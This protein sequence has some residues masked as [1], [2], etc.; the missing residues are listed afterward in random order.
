MK[1]KYIKLKHQVQKEHINSFWEYIE[2][3]VTPKADATISQT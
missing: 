2:D 3:I 1:D